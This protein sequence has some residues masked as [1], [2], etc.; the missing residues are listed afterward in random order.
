LTALSVG[1]GPAES[2]MRSMEKIPHR[3]DIQVRPSY[4]GAGSCGCQKSVE[5]FQALVAVAVD[6]SSS[7]GVEDASSGGHTTPVGRDLNVTSLRP[8]A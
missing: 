5:R 2:A 6:V 1:T 7:S 3:G 4:R 8:G